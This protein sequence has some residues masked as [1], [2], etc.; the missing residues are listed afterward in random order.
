MKIDV[1]DELA[2][3]T[4][5]LYTFF[6]YCLQTCGKPLKYVAAEMGHSPEGLSKRMNLS[7]QEN[8][9]RFTVSDMEVYMERIGDLRPKDFLNKKFDQK[10]EEREKRILNDLREKLPDL[11]MLVE[12]LKGTKEQTG[13]RK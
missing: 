7:P 3:E 9:P 8:S 12:I 10:K 1:L 5:D 11:E 4:D 13:K 6:V 2:M